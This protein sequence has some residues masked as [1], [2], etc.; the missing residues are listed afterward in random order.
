M[1]L[2]REYNPLKKYSV[3]DENGVN[4][5]KLPKLQR[6]LIELDD[7]YQGWDYINK[8]IRRHCWICNTRKDGPNKL[9]L[10]KEVEKAFFIKITLY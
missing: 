8:N 10:Y 1:P 6:S 4:I 5:S 3:F 9:T 7:N 2:R